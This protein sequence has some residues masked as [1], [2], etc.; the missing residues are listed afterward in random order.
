MKYWGSTVS[1]FPR[2]HAEHYSES[3]PDQRKTTVEGIIPHQDAAAHQN[4]VS[5]SEHVYP[6]RC[7]DCK[8]KRTAGTGVARA[9]AGPQAFLSAELC[10]LLLCG[11]GG[12]WA[13]AVCK[14]GQKSRENTSLEGV[15]PSCSLYSSLRSPGSPDQLVDIR[16]WVFVCPKDLLSMQH[17][18]QECFL[19]F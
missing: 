2:L 4:I 3:N 19:L 1:V 12:Q 14:A 5:Y 13:M 17:K 18:A 15:K 8:W 11:A 9:G 7:I 6:N 10:R 16:S